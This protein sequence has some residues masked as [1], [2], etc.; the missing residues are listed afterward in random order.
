[1]PA[2]AG[3]KAGSRGWW[4]ARVTGGA[5]QQRAA[6]AAKIAPVTVV[7]AAHACSPVRCRECLLC[8]SSYRRAGSIVT[9]YEVLCVMC[10]C[11]EVL[12]HL[13]LCSL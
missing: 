5:G 1:M 2:L 11:E 4:P 13:L 9:V 3:G 8:R 12:E 7:A 6:L 10:G